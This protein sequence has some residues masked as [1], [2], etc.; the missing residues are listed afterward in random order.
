MFALTPGWASNTLDHVRG[1]KPALLVAI[2]FLALDPG[3]SAKTFEVTKRGDPAPGTC[4]PQDCSLREAVLAANA[5]AGADEIVMPSRKLHQ[6]SISGDDDGAEVGDLDVTNDPLRIVHP[7]EGRATIDFKP[8]DQGLTDPL[9]RVFEVFQ[10]APL[11]LKNVTITDGGD[12]TSSPNGGGIR[13]LEDLT[14]VRSTLAGN[15]APGSGG[16][17]TVEG[18]ADLVVKRSRLTG[19]EGLGG[20]I[21]LTGTGRMTITAS[22]ILGNRA[23]DFDDDGGA[24]YF[25]AGSD[26]GSSISN[27]T[28]SGNRADDEGGAIYGDG[29]VLRITGSTF[30]ENIAGGPGGAIHDDDFDLTMINSTLTRN[31]SDSN[32]GAIYADFGDSSLNAVTITRNLGNAD[33]LGSE[34]GGGIFVG[35]FISGFRVA[36]SIIALNHVGDLMGGEPVPNE[37]SNTVPFESVGHNLLAT[38]FLCAEFDGPG[39]IARSNPKLGQLGANGGPTKTVALKKGSPAIGH[40]AKGSSPKRDQRGIKRDNKPDTGAYERE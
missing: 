25:G 31:R 17:L 26:A 4:S 35:S 38:R 39:D 2:V 11:T 28:I 34:A 30:S 19:N 33:G 40:A 14:L 29:G 22:K 20:A 8:P 23:P 24:I 32:G 18:G 13:A 27:T 16:G 5:R 7:G 9:D 10:T 1:L 21:A 15:D 12:P 36:N 3:A 6:L 37:C